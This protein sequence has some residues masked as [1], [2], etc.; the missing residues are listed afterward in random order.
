MVSIWVR[1]CFFTQGILKMRWLENLYNEINHIF[2]SGII[3]HSEQKSHGYCTS[4]L[5]HLNISFP[6]YKMHY[7]IANASK[8]TVYCEESI[9]VCGFKNLLHETHTYEVICSLWWMLI[10]AVSLFSNTSFWLLHYYQWKAAAFRAGVQSSIFV[11]LAVSGTVYSVILFISVTLRYNTA[12]K[13]NMSVV[14]SLLFKAHY[15]S[16]WHHKSPYNTLTH[17][18]FPLCFEYTLY[19]M[20]VVS[21]HSRNHL[22]KV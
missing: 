22:H 6:L 13:R 9:H 18:Y 14:G 11:K 4:S 3:I 10:L 16:I 20:Y 1:H 21:L 19:W 8:Y 5:H 7:F 12:L 15:S 17:L 2:W